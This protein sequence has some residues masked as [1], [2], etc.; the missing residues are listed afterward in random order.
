MKDES[1]M[2]TTTPATQST[3]RGP[4]ELVRDNLPTLNPDQMF[5]VCQ[6]LVAKSPRGA[7]TMQAV[8]KEAIDE[9]KASA[10]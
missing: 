3:R 1:G 6:A 2:V 4:F 8:L 9:A 5:E 10:S 7:L